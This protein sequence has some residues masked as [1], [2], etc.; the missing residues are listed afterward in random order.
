MG[1]DSLAVHFPQIRDE[2]YFA[3]CFAHGVEER[4]GREALELSR[5]IVS[6]RPELTGPTLADARTRWTTSRSPRVRRGLS[7]EAED[8]KGLP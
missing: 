2:P 5:M 6:R 3:D 4:H 8:G 1:S 7:K